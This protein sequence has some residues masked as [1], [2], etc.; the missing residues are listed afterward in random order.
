M[1]ADVNGNGVVTVT[2]LFLSASKTAYAWTSSQQAQFSG[3]DSAVQFV[4]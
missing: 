2:E 1:P 4:R 3:S